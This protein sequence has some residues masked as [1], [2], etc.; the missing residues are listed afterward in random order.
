MHELD[1]FDRDFLR[2]TLEIDKHVDGYIDAYV[3]P[4][5]LAAA[6]RATPPRPPEALLEDVQALQGRIPTDDRRAGLT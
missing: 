2:L 4:P 1:A 6:V 5:E 3:G